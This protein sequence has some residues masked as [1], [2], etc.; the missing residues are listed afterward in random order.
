MFCHHIK[1]TM[2]LDILLITLVLFPPKLTPL[3]SLNWN[4]IIRPAIHQGTSGMLNA[5]NGL[6]SSNGFWRTINVQQQGITFGQGYWQNTANSQ[7]CTPFRI[8]GYV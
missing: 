2:F 5:N 3:L 8:Y 6:N 1:N 7:Y 4:T